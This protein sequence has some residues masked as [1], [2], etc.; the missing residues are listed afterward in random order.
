MM[1]IGTLKE[2]L[3]HSCN[4]LAHEGHWDNILGHVSIR[5]PKEQKILM[6]PHGFGFEEIRPKHLI[7]CNLDG[8][9][10]EGRYERHSEVYIHTE[11]YKRRPDVNC[12]IH[13][14]P[15]ATILCTMTD[16]PL[17]MITGHPAPVRR[18]IEA[19]GIPIFGRAITLHTRAET[20]PMVDVMQDKNG[21]LMR[22]HGLAAAGASIAEA[23]SLA[24]AIESFCRFSWAASLRG[25][26]VPDISEEDK[27]TFA[28]RAGTESQD[29]LH[30]VGGER[31]PA[32]DGEGTSWDYLTALLE[33]GALQFDEMMA[34]GAP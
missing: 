14:H 7:V 2:A 20:V 13:A 1:N 29:E 12:V 17:R 19:G 25:V 3:A 16:L 32:S 21:C 31:A 6:K 22:A 4:I 34:L 26:P 24:L 8:E 11:I 5:I 9:K 33:T 23:T 10:I 15:P 27:R 28:G 18:M 30:P